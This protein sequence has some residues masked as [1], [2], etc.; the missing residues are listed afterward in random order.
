MYIY[1]QI[2]FIY[3][4]IRIDICIHMYVCMYIYICMCLYIYISKFVF[5]F[6][7][8]HYCTSREHVFVDVSTTALSITC[9]S[10]SRSRLTKTSCNSCA[11]AQLF[12][13][14]LSTHVIVSKFSLFDVFDNSLVFVVRQ[15]M[16][17]ARLLQG[18]LAKEA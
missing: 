11:T 2:C 8:I 3:I 6:Y 17:F 14:S 13:L 7:Y 4:H 5:A 12:F 15:Y 1:T 16:N 10:A 9:E 18:F